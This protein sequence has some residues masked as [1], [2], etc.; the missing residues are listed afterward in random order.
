MPRLDRESEVRKVIATA[1]IPD[2]KRDAL[3]F[4]GGHTAVPG[5][6]LRAFASGYT[7]YILKY[8]VEQRT[9]AQL[10]NPPGRALARGPRPECPITE[11][12]T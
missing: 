4:D 11:S 8:V 7:A 1:V 3:I 2:G 12:K 9:T 10:K 5:F 6:A